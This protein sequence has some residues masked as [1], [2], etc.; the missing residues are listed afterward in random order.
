MPIAVTTCFC[1]S[2][3]SM[4]R[5]F[6][7]KADYPDWATIPIAKGKAEAKALCNRLPQYE[8]VDML[9]GFLDSA[10]TW[11]V[12]IGWDDEGNCRWADISKGGPKVSIPAEFLVKQ[13]AGIA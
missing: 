5:N 8:E 4:A 6:L 10:S 2:V 9:R 3:D 13:F 1:G 11:V 7:R 12:I